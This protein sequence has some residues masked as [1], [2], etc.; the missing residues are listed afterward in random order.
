MAPDQEPL[1]DR[2]QYVIRMCVRAMAV[3]MVFVIIMGVVDVGWVIWQRLASPPRFIL[4]IADML[5]TFGAFMAVLVAIEI[6][7]NITIYLREEVIHIKIVIA[8]ALMAVARKVIILDQETTQPMEMF[9]LALLVVATS[10]GYWLV[11]NTP[12]V[13][14]RLARKDNAE[15]PPAR[16]DG[17][18]GT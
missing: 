9:G 3:M 12:P 13:S 5:A 10:V 1:I 11:Q 4:T 6:F 15:T 18:A 16:R 17:D 2:L 7:V 8:T 14:V